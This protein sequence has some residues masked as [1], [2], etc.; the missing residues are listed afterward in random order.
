MPHLSPSDFERTPKISTLYVVFF[1]E[2]TTR[3]R[4]WGLTQWLKMVEEE[5]EEVEEEFFRL[6]KVFLG[7]LTFFFF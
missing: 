4:P 1:K 6:K 5:D 3:L 7:F 2:R